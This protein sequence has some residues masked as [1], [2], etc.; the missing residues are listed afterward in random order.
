MEKS[1]LTMNKPQLELYATLLG[2]IKNRIRQAQIKATLSANGEMIAMY[3]DIGKMIQERQQLKGWSAAVIPRLSKDIR[4]ELPEIKGFSERSIGRMLSFYRHYPILPQ[5][6]AK[7]GNDSN[8][9][10]PL[11][12]I[13]IQDL[14]LQI[15]WGHHA[16]L[17]EKVKDISTR[18]WYMQQ[19]LA[20]GWSRDIL[21]LM[22]KTNLYE[23]QGNAPN[24]FEHTLPNPHSDLVKQMLK[25]P[26]I[27]DFFTLTERFDERELE[28]ELIKHLEKFLLE[29]G[30][31]FAF[32]GRQFHI[33]VSDKDFYIDLLF[34][35]L[36]LRCFVII[37]LKKGD[38]KPEHAG[39]VSFYC[40]VVDDLMKHPSDQP[41]IGLILCQN[42]D[43]VIAEY[44]L[45]NI[46][47]PIGVSAYELTRA[48]PDN[49]K[50][51]LPSIEDLEAEMGK[52]N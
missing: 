33:V 12:K 52:T 35:H 5:A 10:Q 21:A 26:Y 44:A 28:T 34:Y 45:R 47:Q 25:D 17:I 46:G 27:F 15:P 23:R 22:I 40:S 49:F 18:F 3:W 11:A 48:L 41:S 1:L 32:V 4:N 16:I 31:G 50:S 37:D 8:L 2:D 14:V 29:L 20:N 9:P 24:N 51:S 38:F 6:V 39:K 7:L 30:A 43:R 13:E 36:K 42:K 19:T